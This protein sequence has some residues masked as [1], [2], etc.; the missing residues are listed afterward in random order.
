MG[1]AQCN[2]VYELLVWNG[3]EDK[4]NVLSGSITQF[5]PTAIVKW[6]RVLQIW[7][8]KDGLGTRVISSRK[9]DFLWRFCESYFRC[10]ESR[11]CFCVCEWLLLRLISSSAVSDEFAIATNMAKAKP[12]LNPCSDSEHYQS[13][14]YS[15]KSEENVDLIFT[16]AENVRCMQQQ[17]REDSSLSRV[18]NGESRATEMWKSGR[19]RDDSTRIRRE[20]ERNMKSKGHHLSGNTK[21]N[22]MQTVH[23]IF[24][25]IPYWKTF[26]I[27]VLL[28]VFLKSQACSAKCYGL[29]STGRAILTDLQGF[30]SDHPNK[31]YPISTECE[32]LIQGEKWSAELHD[33]LSFLQ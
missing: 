33:L 25:S 16:L 13:G 23:G 4:G 1:T 17:G 31:S 29:G 2:K 27:T 20:S 8:G 15:K 14:C 30:I 32:W 6:K 5:L 28:C 21:R 18:R 24:P 19:L 9:V 26:L 11:D 10:I 7:W 22:M 3:N 12:K